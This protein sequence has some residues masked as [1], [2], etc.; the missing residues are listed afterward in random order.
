MTDISS[1]KTKWVKLIGKP[2]W[3]IAIV[4]EID[5]IR[6]NMR[7]KSEREQDA[8]KKELYDFFELHLKNGDI[9]LEENPPDADIERQSIDM[10]VIHHTSNPPGMSRERLSGAELIR[11]YAPYFYAPKSEAD[12]SMKGRPIYSGHVRNGRQV[13]WPYHWFIR[14]DGTAERLLEDSEI[15]WQA[16]NWD[17]NRRSVAI[18]FDGDYENSRPSDTELCAAAKLI[19][20]RYSGV[21]QEKIFGHR[22]INPKTT[23]PSNLFLSDDMRQGWK[24]D[25]LRLI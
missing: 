13:F 19:R 21:A 10:V 9:A 7:D 14:K 20:E 17:V 24:E 16:G 12:R 1:I 22:E 8:C 23:C 2:D 3:Y 25:L 18:C 15:G 4:P 6:K 5:E 11:L